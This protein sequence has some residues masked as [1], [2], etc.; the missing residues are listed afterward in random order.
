M[1]FFSASHLQYPPREALDRCLAGSLILDI[2]P[3]VIC[4]YKAFDV[5]EVVYCPLQ[6]LERLIDRLPTDR[7]IIVAD[8]TGIHAREA[9]NLLIDNGYKQVAGLAGG[10][11]EWE[12]DGLPL[13][14]DNKARLSGSCMCQLKFR[15]KTKTK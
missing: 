5:P 7:E 10:M 13:K 3:E 9:I 6:E 11:V 8:S 12:R 2:R 14:L 15:E 1:S 4:A